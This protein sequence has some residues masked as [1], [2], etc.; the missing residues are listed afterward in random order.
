[1]DIVRWPSVHL[2]DGLSGS[3]HEVSEETVTVVSLKIVQV[4]GSRQVSV[5]ER[6]LGAGERRAGFNVELRCLSNLKIAPEGSRNENLAGNLRP[7]KTSAPPGSEQ[8]GWW[9]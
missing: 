1:M 4:P 6:D 8:A 3:G 7:V 9:G 5:L 2:R